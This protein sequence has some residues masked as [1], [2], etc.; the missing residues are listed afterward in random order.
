VH[1]FVILANAGIHVNYIRTEVG[2][3]K[4][5]E[6]LKIEPPH[7]IPAEAGIQ[8]ARFMTWI[9]AEYSEDDIRIGNPSNFLILHCQS[10]GGVKDSDIK[11]F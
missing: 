8:S 5:Y 10:T 4:I 3:P 7:V 11:N 6:G 1:L 2:P 9:P